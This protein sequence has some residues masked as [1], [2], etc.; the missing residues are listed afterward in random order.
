[1][2]RETD[3]CSATDGDADAGTPD[4]PASASDGGEDAG[5]IAAIAPAA[6]PEAEAEAETGELATAM[7]RLAMPSSS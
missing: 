1:M 4:E 2:E 6:E 5:D 7:P 3:A